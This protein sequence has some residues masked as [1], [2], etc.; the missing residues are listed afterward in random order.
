ME[1]ILTEAVGQVPAL[2]TFCVMLGFFIKYLSSRDRLNKTIA[3]ECHSVQ[4]EANKVIKDNT[5]VIGAVTQELVRV[6][7]VMDRIEI[8]INSTPKSNDHLRVVETHG[9]GNK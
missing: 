5:R 6:S 1:K 4:K 7:N 8:K 2:V 9:D 3:D